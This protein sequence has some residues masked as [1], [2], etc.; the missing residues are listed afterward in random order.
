MGSAHIYVFVSLYSDSSLIFFTVFEGYITPAALFQVLLFAC[1]G[2]VLKKS[3]RFSL[4]LVQKPRAAMVATI[5]F[6]N[7]FDLF[8]ILLAHYSVKGIQILS[9]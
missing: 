1:S 6:L 7:F 2:Y 8:T 4:K 3:L 9:K 5:F